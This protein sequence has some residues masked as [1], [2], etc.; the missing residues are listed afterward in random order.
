MLTS[1]S[2]NAQS[3]LIFNKRT[4]Q[5]EDQWIAFKMSEDS[6]YRFGFVYIDE[7]AGLTYQMEGSFKINTEGIFIPKKMDDVNAKFRLEPNN[8]KVAIIPKDRYKELMITEEPDWLH[9][10]KET[11]DSVGRMVRWGFFYNSWDDC[12]KALTFL[13]K[14]Y[15]IDPHHAGLEFE[16]SYA[17]NALEQY[18]KAILVLNEA[19]KIN[20]NDC[21]FYKELSYA[22]C[23]TGKLDDASITSKKATSTCTD[24][25][26]IAEI[27]YNLAYQY[28]LKKDKANFKKWAK[29]TKKNAKGIDEVKLMIDN[30]GTMNSKL[31]N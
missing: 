11:K 8:V 24:K 22:E 4:V 17:Y 29:I 3:K 21:L 2:S 16:L 9:F 26:L 5:C 1:I 10:Y 19:I 14:A 6:S 15:S 30:L 12:E 13:E 7:Q 23:K 31:T 18:D 27:T 28:Y 25:K 20:P